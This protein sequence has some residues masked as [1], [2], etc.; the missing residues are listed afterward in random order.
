MTK[1]KN[2][3]VLGGIHPSIGLS[4]A[5]QK[6]LDSLIDAMQRSVVYWVRAAYNQKPP[7]M[8]QDVDLSGSPAVV[9]QR[10][11]RRLAKKWQTKFDEASLP[12]ARYF[13]QAVADRTDSQLRSVLRKG[14]FSV[15]FKPTR[16]MN[17]IIQANVGGNVSLIKS[18][19]ERYFTDVEGSVMRSVAKGRD[20]GGL[21]IELQKTYGITK[22]RAKLIAHHQNN[23]ATGQ[24]QKARQL[25]LGITKA[26]WCHSHG[27]K[28]P[29]PN[30]V[31]AGAEKLQY[32]VAKGAYIDG[33]YIFP[34]ELVNC[35]C[36]SRPLLI[37]YNDK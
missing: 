10:V 21:T 2:D 6:K 13:S 20:V 7:E 4:E 29:R 28:E 1:N 8:A 9:M 32:D 24:M 30:H 22:R 27:G 12:L 31:K 16:A 35:R 17:D 5:Y 37:G 25:E 19:P 26:I 23:L 11:M 34:G 33:E 15:K 3:K 14:G 18:I 36:F